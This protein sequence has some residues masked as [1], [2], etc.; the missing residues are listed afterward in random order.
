MRTAA[1]LVGVLALGSVTACDM[2]DDPPSVALEGIVT[3][4]NFRS[5]SAGCTFALKAPS[6]PKPPVPA[7]PAPAKP[8]APAPV[9]TVAPA[10]SAAAPARATGGYGGAP[11]QK[12]VTRQTVKV[13]HPVVVPYYGYSSGYHY[14]Y[15]NDCWRVVF[16]T[17]SGITAADCV[18]W[19]E[20]IQYEIGFHYPRY[21]DG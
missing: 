6:I 10:K 9:K 4:L 8:V 21:K 18:P 16:R 17:E 11:A 2:D 1:L 19:S 12:P 3:D 14:C 15:R 13:Y 7:K 5:G 20:Y